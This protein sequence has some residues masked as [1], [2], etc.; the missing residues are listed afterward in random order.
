MTSTRITITIEPELVAE[1][2]DLGINISAAASKG[3]KS[4]IDRERKIKE[5]FPE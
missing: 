1:A 3:L 5:A 2:R 4:A